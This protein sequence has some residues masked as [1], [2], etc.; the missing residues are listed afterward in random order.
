M[1][2]T[3]L[4]GVAMPIQGITDV[5]AKE[6]SSNGAPTTNGHASL[7]DEPSMAA[8]QDP[9][10]TTPTHGHQR[11]SQVD[12]QFL[13]ASMSPTQAKR[14]L[15]AHLA[16]TERRIQEASRLGTTLIEQRKNLS[17]RLK[18]VDGKQGDG[19]IGPELRQKLAEI[20]REYNEVG[21]ESARA[22]LGPRSRVSS[23]E[24]AP[25]SPFAGDGRVSPSVS[26]INATC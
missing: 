6:P 4:G 20:E 15:E 5:M 22:F 1:T 12:S 17:D 19:E 9:F 7:G 26:S 18:D 10:V 13:A 24:G 3:K 21:R 14:A 23:A 11:F 2:D 8:S 25:N 16:E